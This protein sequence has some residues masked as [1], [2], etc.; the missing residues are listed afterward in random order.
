MPV[1][2]LKEELALPKSVGEKEYSS[3][4]AAT[5]A[6]GFLKRPWGRFPDFGGILHGL[7]LFVRNA[8]AHARTYITCITYI[9]IHMH[10]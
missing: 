2:G 4:P 8:H 6:G 3:S 7:L 9:H 1:H 5:V 10:I